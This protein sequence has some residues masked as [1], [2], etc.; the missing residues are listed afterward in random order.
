M[1][2]SEDLTEVVAVYTIHH[3]LP[4]YPGLFVVV[5][6][7]VLSCGLLHQ[8]DHPWA[9]TFDL[10]AARNAIPAGMVQLHPAPG[11]APSIVEVWV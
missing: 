4:E 8:D 9:A 11:D 1:P 10:K 3:G 6:G 7:A 5:R 2:V